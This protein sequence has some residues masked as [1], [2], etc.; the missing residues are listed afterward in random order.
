MI[1]SYSDDSIDSVQRKFYSNFF[2]HP[3][4]FKKP[5][6]ERH[7]P[8]SIIDDFKNSATVSNFEFATEMP[9]E[10][11]GDTSIATQR[12]KYTVTVQIKPIE[13]DLSISEFDSLADRIQKA[14]FATLRLGSFQK[15][16]AFLRDQKTQKTTPFE[17]D[18]TFDI[19]PT[20]LLRK[21]I[22]INDNESDFKRIR[23]YCF[24]L[25]E[26]LKPEIYTHGVQ[27]R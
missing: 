12:N 4:Q 25:L 5:T 8:Q 20:I 27:E 13:R 1:Q 22:T 15:K 3:K 16:R 23:Q 7:I 11:L 17:L 19:H 26:T 6:I 21:Y 9:G 18:S 14:I 10:T 24:D 2:R